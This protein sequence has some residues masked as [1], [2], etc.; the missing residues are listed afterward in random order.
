LSL[1]TVA[2]CRLLDTRTIAAGELRAGED[3]T[4]ALSG[5][6]GVP[7]EARAVSL[8]VAVTAATS[9]G[10]VRIWPADGAPPL[11]STINFSRGQ[12]RS[13]NAIVGLDAFGLVKVRS[14]PEGSVH[15][16]VDVNGYFR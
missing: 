11:A 8:N 12:T 7:D 15:L 5:N 14:E 2:P 1:Y 4:F 9:A 13:N 10:H 6:C 3:R 16:I